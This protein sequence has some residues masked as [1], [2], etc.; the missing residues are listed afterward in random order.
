MMNRP[1]PTTDQLARTAPSEV[2]CLACGSRRLVVGFAR[3]DIGDCPDC[4]YSGWADPQLLSDHDRS[5]LHRSLE[6]RFEL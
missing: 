2:E 3:A 4:G 1:N 5:V 6:A